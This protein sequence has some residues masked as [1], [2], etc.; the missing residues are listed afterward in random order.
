MKAL[1]LQA[2]CRALKISQVKELVEEI[3]RLPREEQV[4]PLLLIINS[5]IGTRLHVD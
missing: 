4:E 3:L 1:A 5:L 2:N